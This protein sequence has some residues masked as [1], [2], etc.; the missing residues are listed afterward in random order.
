MNRHSFALLIPSLGINRDAQGPEPMAPLLSPYKLHSSSQGSVS[1]PRNQWSLPLMHNRTCQ[2]AT[3]VD[4]GFQRQSCGSYIERD[5]QDGQT[6]ASLHFQI[7]SKRSHHGLISLAGLGFRAN[8]VKEGRTLK[9]KAGT[10]AVNTERFW[11]S[12]EAA[13]GERASFVQHKP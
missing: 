4:L 8:M 1:Q 3:T 5:V 7:T 9:L 2:K 6:L 13:R 11:Q 10:A 12:E